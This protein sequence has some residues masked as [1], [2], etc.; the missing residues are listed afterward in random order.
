[1]LYSKAPHIVRLGNIAVA[2]AISTPLNDHSRMRTWRAA[3][4][5]GAPNNR[6]AVADAQLVLKN[7]LGSHLA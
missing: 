1:M 4:A 6:A 7:G 2:R 3:G 5:I